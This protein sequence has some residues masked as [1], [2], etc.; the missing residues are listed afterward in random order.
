MSETE[1]IHP[2]A[3]KLGAFGLRQLSAIE[4][5]LQACASC[6][7][8]VAALIDHHGRQARYDIVVM[9]NPP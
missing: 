2:P 6:R 8:V 3:E 4:S 5:H 1:P 7:Q 9:A